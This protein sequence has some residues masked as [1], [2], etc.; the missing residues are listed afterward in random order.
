[1]QVVGFVTLGFERN[2]L[3]LSREAADIG[4]SSSAIWLDVDGLRLPR[5]Q[6][7]DSHYVIVSGRFNASS[8]GHMGMFA[9]TIESISRLEMWH[10]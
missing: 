9:G 5:P 7:Y 3:Y 8:R 1:V 4:D 6:G 2:A 10:K